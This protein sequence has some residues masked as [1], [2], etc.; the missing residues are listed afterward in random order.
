M[1]RASLQLL[2][3]PIFLGLAACSSQQVD[4]GEVTGTAQETG[5]EYSLNDKN[6]FEWS[7]DDVERGDSGNFEGGKRSRYDGRGESSYAKSRKTPGYMTREYHSAAW[8]GKKDYSTGSY[9]GS[10]KS[11]RDSK[12][13]WFGWNKNLNADKVASASGKNYKAGSY[14][15]GSARESGNTVASPSSPYADYRQRIGTKPMVIF[16]QETYRQMSMNQSRGL[17]GKP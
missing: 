13:S 6:P 11:S 10:T 17:L 15:T 5:G 4:T 12:R 8:N 1:S 3:I 7:A 9:S 16:S 2:Y 14:N